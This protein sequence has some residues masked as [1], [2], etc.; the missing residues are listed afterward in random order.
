MKILSSYH[1]QR[2]WFIDYFEKGDLYPD[3]PVYH[4]IPLIFSV[5]KQLSYEGVEK[6]VYQLL[7]KNEVLRTSFFRSEGTIFQEIHEIK[8]IS[9]SK[10]LKKEIDLLSKLKDLQELAF[11][12]DNNFLIKCY[13]ENLK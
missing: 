5:K 6:A 7:S 13:F 3:G 2:L 9:I 11:T 8:E 12:F 10:I 1:Q 4:N